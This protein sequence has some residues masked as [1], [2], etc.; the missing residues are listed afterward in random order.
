LTLSGTGVL[1]GTP[2][3][4]GTF[5]QSVIVQDSAG[6]TASASLSL[7][8]AASS[9]T[10][11]AAINTDAHISADANSPSTAVNSPAF[12]TAAGNELLLAFIA[13]DANGS[14]NATVTGV[15]GGGLVWTLVVR[16][17]VRR[18]T[19]EIWRAFAPS[20]L[21]NVSVTAT[22]S[23][24]VVS[25]MTVM[26][27]AGVDTS[28][29]NGAGAI[30]ASKAAN[31]IGTPTATLTTTRNNSW[32]F[33]VGN[34]YDNAIVRTPGTAQAIV[35]QDLSATNDTYWVQMQNA[36]TPLSGTSVSISDSAPT[37]D[38]YN[39]AIVEI[40]PSSGAPSPTYSISGTISGAVVSGVTLNLSGTSTASTTTDVSGNYVFAGL[41]N[42]GYTVTPG[43]AGF[44]FTPASQL[45][46]VNDANVPGI[47]F[48]SAAIPTYSISGTVFGPVVSGV[49]VNLSG[50]S[51]GATTTDAS[52]N[53]T[54]A[55][56]SNGSYTITPSAPGYT[57]T[58]SNQPATINS[59]GIP[60]VNFT[61][62]EP[63]PPATDPP[64]T[65]SPSTLAMD[66]K[67]STDSGRVSTIASPQ[68][69]T[70]FANELLLAFIS[71]DYLGGSNV[72]VT[73]VNGAGLVWVLVARTNAQSG[74]S[75]IWRAFASS[76]LSN[77]TVAATLSQS[78]ASSMTVITFTGVDTS[79]TNGSG[80]IGATKS[81]SS[82]RGAP[83]ARLVTTRN[84]SWVFG[85]G[86][87]YDNPIV[88][89]PGMGQ[90]LIHQD[91]SSTGDTY[92]V[93]MQNAPTLLSGTSVA[94]SDTAPTF[95]RY[96]LA[97]C[98]ILPAP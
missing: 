24:S 81:A 75:E 44:T 15:N 97:I 25:S 65:A 10:T 17:N 28:G 49:T 48:T 58:P 72:T 43:D 69:S 94:I 62:Q 53:F 83:T 34:D 70:N 38:Q 95:D 41:S 88:R 39:L 31:G 96:N 16:A 80:A 4:A 9:S 1:S 19:S 42:G 51:S 63:A 23:Q 54:F 71:T 35:H 76:P 89:I 6:A 21:S 18:G 90:S 47:D 79:G 8:V 33:G 86:N 27:F 20:M 84:N 92:W 74:T 64:G 91:M 67:I 45:A 13:T 61:S 93:Q 55:G 36:P 77:A 68:F 60:G 87:D 12:S 29:T 46:T 78:V 3:Q 37:G 11:L 56:L 22:L 85:V 5:P 2:A 50:T 73:E 66:T 40:L 57:F 59:A 52:G 30:G 98:E 14:T 82:W 26:S 32:I 7:S